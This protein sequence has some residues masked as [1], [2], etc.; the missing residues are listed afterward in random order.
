MTSLLEK[1]FGVVLLLMLVCFGLLI[2]GYILPTYDDTT[3]E[4]IFP[5][6][7]N[8]DNLNR[9]LVD[10]VDYTEISNTDIES[11]QTG[12]VTIYAK[13]VDDDEAESQ[14]TGFMYT[15]EH[16]MTNNHVVSGTSEFYI[17]YQNGEWSSAEIVGK[18]S[19]TDIAVLKPESI[20]DYVSVLPMQTNSPVIGE[21]VVA[22]G[23]PSGLD[24]TLTNGV[25]SSNDVFMEIESEYGIPDSIQTDAALNPGNSGGP[26]VSKSE[27]AV[28]G[29]N[30]ATLGENIG[31]AI[32]SRVAHTVGQ[33][34]IENGIHRHSYLGIKTTQLEPNSS[35]SEGMDINSGLVVSEIPSD[36]PAS[37]LD[38]YSEDDG[39]ESPDVIVGVNGKEV[40]TTNDLSSHFA[41]KTEPNDEVELDIYRD[42][43]IITKKVVLGDRVNYQ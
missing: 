28:V 25:I 23:A 33:S 18:D 13:R 34:L 21:S 39:F 3:D 15:G 11:A 30:R 26:L 43:E 40:Q 1:L 5:D 42:G 29:V 20:P 16:I 8:Y 36:T 32:S 27:G 14:G 24:S 17:Q 41:L 35:I 2:G 22:I 6:N 31:Y 37:D 10:S 19:D 38:L 7:D 12:I 4:E 9:T